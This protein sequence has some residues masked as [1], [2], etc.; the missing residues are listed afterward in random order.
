MVIDGMRAPRFA[1]DVA[2]ING[3]IAFVES[4][5]NQRAGRC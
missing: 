1:A 3:R 5:A 2:V 4:L